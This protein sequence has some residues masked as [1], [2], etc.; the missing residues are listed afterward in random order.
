[1]KPNA[2]KLSLLVIAIGVA[3]VL[4]CM[5]PRSATRQPRAS[6]SQ[7]LQDVRAGK[8]DAVT[9]GP[10]SSGAVPATYRLKDGNA[11]RTV[12]PSNYRDAMT[13]MQAGAVN[14][15]IKEPWL[16]TAQPLVNMIPFLILVAV[17]LFMMRR[18]KGRTGIA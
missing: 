1:M 9:I 17:W 15:E 6:Y 7:F 18:L 8:V 3:T 11:A 14:I 10:A 2:K 4:F 16:S 5:S 12:L 13:A